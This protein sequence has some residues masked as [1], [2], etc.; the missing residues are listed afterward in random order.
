M[1]E[2]QEIDVTITADGRLAVEVHGL[3]GPGGL[4]LT[5]ALEASL[6]GKVVER[7]LT[8][9]HDQQPVAD[10]PRDRLRRGD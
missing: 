7:R 2:I 10:R 5:R 8:H 1:N 9:E 4:E 3:K 6:G